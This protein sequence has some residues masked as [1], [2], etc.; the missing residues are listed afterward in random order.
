[1]PNKAL[2]FLEERRLKG[3]AVT[4]KELKG[5]FG[6]DE[7][8]KALTLQRKKLHPE[9]EED[10]VMGAQSKLRKFFSKR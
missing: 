9:P 1:M 10:D 4:G 7:T 5:K 3:L 2:D 6:N 8:K